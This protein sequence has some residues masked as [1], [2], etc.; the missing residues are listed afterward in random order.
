MKRIVWLISISIVSTLYAAEPLVRQQFNLPTSEQ[1]NQLS[2]IRHI[3]FSK[4][5][6]VFVLASTATAD[7]IY[8]L[9]PT[10]NTWKQIFSRPQKN[11]IKTIHALS[12]TDLFIV[13]ENFFLYWD[14]IR[15]K[16]PI[17]LSKENFNLA[18]NNILL[19][20]AGNS[21]QKLWITYRKPNNTIQ[22]RFFRIRDAKIQI[23]NEDFN[24]KSI[25]VAH[26]GVTW[27]LDN[28]GTILNIPSIDI[29]ENIHETDISP[30]ITLK[31]ISI[32]LSSIYAHDSNHIWGIDTQGDL[33]KINQSE[34]KIVL[35]NIFDMPQ[36][37]YLQL[38]SPN[39][40]PLFAIHTNGK[41]YTLPLDYKAPTERIIAPEEKEI[42][43]EPKQIQ[44]P[45]QEVIEQIQPSLPTKEAAKKL[46]G[47]SVILQK[48][49][50]LPQSNIIRRFP[51]QQRPIPPSTTQQ[52]PEQPTSLPRATTPTEWKKFSE[53][54]QDPTFEIGFNA[55]FIEG[56]QANPAYPEIISSLGTFYNQGIADGAKGCVLDNFFSQL[57]EILTQESKK[58]LMERLLSAPADVLRGFLG[59]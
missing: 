13:S 36:N 39:N 16:Y 33:Y 34:K 25:S 15:N 3:T 35:F 14:M 42:S 41:V 45:P 17:G 58:I 32:A 11:Y 51:T 56:L 50:S 7:A 40:G 54:L 6:R 18:P 52:V 2:N 28:T 19:N 59:Q 12:D 26:D 30:Q 43:E 9:D 49:E 57:T 37:G 24:Y 44:Q 29:K 21:T 4:N 47:L 27:L 48:P 10:T 22:S 38:T 46:A 20:V 31:N 8:T 23:K 55:G 5:N 53:E 1:L